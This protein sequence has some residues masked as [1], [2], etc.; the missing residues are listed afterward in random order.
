MPTKD[1][2]TVDERRKYLKRMK[3]RYEAAKRTER[4][5]LLSEMEQVTG[6]HRKSLTRLLHEDSLERQPRQ[7]QRSQSYGLEVERVVIRVWESLDYVCAER[8][9]PVLWPTAQ[10][11]ARFG[12]LC[13]TP[14]LEEALHRISRAT[15]E[16]M[17]RKNRSRKARLPQKG[18]ERANQLTKGVPMGRIPWNISEPG[19]FEVDLVHHSG[20]STAGD[21]L[22]TLQVIDVATG[23]SERVAVLGRS[24]RAMEAGFRV[25]LARVPLSL[26]SCIQT[27][28]RSFLTSTWFVF[29]ASRS[30]DSPFRE[31]VPIRKRIIGWSSRKTTAWCGSI[32]GL[33][34]WI[35]RS[36]CRP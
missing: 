36:N 7:I 23:R 21:Y 6:M 25:L 8:L 16:R 17:L 29:G 14:D 11:L 22:H 1:D 2:M 13:V 28:A 27:M 18:P 5:R 32:L 10:H 24:G 33:F 19:R 34:G 30:P 3:L 20:E 9:T 31:A 35:R 15:V 26:V 12:V 4:S